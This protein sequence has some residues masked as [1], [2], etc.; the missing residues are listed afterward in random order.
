[1]AGISTLPPHVDQAWLDAAACEVSIVFPCLNE[2][3][4]VGECVENGVGHLES[5]GIAGEVVVCDN[6]SQ[7]GS[8]LEAAR[9]G[10]R[11]V[12]EAAR[13]YGSALRTGIRAA[14][15]EYI[16]MLD[17]DGSY[18]LGAIAPM[19]AALRTGADL[20]MGNRFRGRLAPGA[21]PWLNRHVGSPLLSWLLNLFFGTSVGDVHCGMRAFT[22]DAYHRLALKT[23]GMEFASEMVAR[24]ARIKLRI[25][26]VPVDY[27]P[28]AGES[29]LRRYRDGWRHLRFLLMYSPTWVFMIPSV[30]MFLLGFMLL[31][32]L[33]FSP[34]T[35]L[36][37]QWDM[38]LAA[39]ASMLCVLAA[40]AA[41]LGISAR[42]VAVIHGFDPED[43]FI[44]AFYQ[45][46]TLER[47]LVVAL[48][49]LIAGAI[50]AGWVI[51][52]WAANGFPPLDEIRPLLLGVTLVIVGV[53]STFN[54]FFLSLLGI[55][56]RAVSRD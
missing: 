51:S 1:V 23:T 46:F 15:G 43:R 56:T 24:A 36:G 2:S 35:F 12:H 44:T 28:R 48:A 26:E 8:A 7:D 11:V 16:V 42:T 17:A 19:V 9:A 29:K 40:Q 55:E 45:R 10:A 6:G 31:V 30:L 34:L 27:H 50:V 18:D 4:S 21:M 37:R 25:V 53:Q 49:F 20:V 52:R 47:G 32:A 38:H 22:R 13:G 54:A 5:A 41:W 33:A 3:S 14:Q 39:V